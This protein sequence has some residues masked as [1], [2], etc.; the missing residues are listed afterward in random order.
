MSDVL[1]YRYGC[2]VLVFF[3]CCL[4]GS[5]VVKSTW[6]VFLAAAGVHVVLAF[7]YGN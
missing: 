1:S 4:T 7:L 5:C 2:L 6:W 3:Q